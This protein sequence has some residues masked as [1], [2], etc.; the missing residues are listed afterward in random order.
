MPTD[1]NPMESFQRVAAEAAAREAAGPPPPS[2]EELAHRKVVE[3]LEHLR[4]VGRYA[5]H[6]ATCE[7]DV[8][9]EAVLSGRPVGCSCGL[10]EA[11]VRAAAFA[12]ANRS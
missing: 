2:P 6:L 12:L 9:P 3:G 5:Q 10:D 8:S 7:K 1:E 4:A 11:L